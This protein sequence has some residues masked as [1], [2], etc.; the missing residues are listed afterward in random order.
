MRKAFTIIEI[1][2]SVMIIS[3][4]ILG[5]AKIEEKNI[6]I[7]RYIGYRGANE[8]ANTLFFPLSGDT[9]IKGEKANAYDA[10]GKAIRIKSDDM[11]SILKN[12]ERNVTISDSIPLS[13]EELPV[14]LDVRALMIKG[15][16]PSRYYVI[17]IGKSQTRDGETTSESFK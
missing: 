10:I 7:A 14:S 9:E 17:E 4:V 3:V 12:I 6:S 15:E 11:K 13:E 8:F 5:I 2:V 1:F 16:Y